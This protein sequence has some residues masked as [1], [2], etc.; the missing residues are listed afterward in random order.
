MSDGLERNTRTVM[1]LTAA[2]RFAGLVRES[3]LSRLIG[4]TEAMSAFA[5][6]FLIPNLFRRLFGEGALSAAF[7][8]TYQRLAD[9][10]PFRAAALAGGM[11]GLLSLVLGGIVVVGEMVL[12]LVSAATEHTHEWLWL[13]MLMLPYMPLVCV[14]AIAGAILHVHGRFG[15]TAAAPILLNGCLIAIALLGAWYFG[16]DDHAR[17]LKVVSVMAGGVVL[18]GVLQVVWSLVALRRAAAWRLDLRDA[19]EPIREILYRAGPMM[20]GLGVLQI[21]TLIDGLIASWPLI[22]PS[23]FGVPYPLDVNSMADLTFAQRL[24]QFPL[25]VFGIAVATA[26]YPLLSRRSTDM[27]A[28]VHTVRRGARLV[29][30]IGLPA[31]IGLMFVRLPLVEVILQGGNFGEADSAR[32]AFVL[33]GYAASVWAYALVQVLTRAFYARDEVMTP[34]RVAMGMVLLNLTLNITLI[35]TPLGVAGLAW[36]T[37]ICAV[38]QVLLL[39]FV[40]HHR[41]VLLWCQSVRIS[42]CQSLVLT[43]FM[44]A[45]LVGAA[46]FLPASTSWWGSLV[47]LTLLTLV[48]G[49]MYWGGAVLWKMPEWRWAIGQAVTG[50]SAMNHH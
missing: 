13:M 17:R 31:G 5:F 38:I 8:P 34:V 46:W 19:T 28:F 27:A 39:V 10:D 45:C 50:E 14:V 2:S 41:G 21:N 16:V 35:W 9:N 11:L 6:A 44:A 43:A 48:G 47:N 26:I 22:S 40:L 7:L 33:L 1:L 42:L 37:A 23:I 29:F 24:Y 3:V 30:F 20:L 12:F 32:V 49:G 4:T 25:G 15:P 18:A 36:S